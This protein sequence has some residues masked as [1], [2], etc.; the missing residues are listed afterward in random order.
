MDGGELLLITALKLEAE[1]PEAMRRY[2][3]RLAGAGVAGIG[4]AVGLHYEEIPKAL[5]DAAENE[6]LPLLEVPRRTPS[7]PSPKPSPPRSP[8]ISTA[9]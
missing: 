9:P 2:V 3:K 7:S 1:N 5:V 6:G 8:P 4:F